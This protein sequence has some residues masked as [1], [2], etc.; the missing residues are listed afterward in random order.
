MQNKQTKIQ[1]YDITFLLWI[2]KSIKELYSYWKKS[3]ISGKLKSF[4]SKFELELSAIQR[5]NMEN[6]SNHKVKRKIRK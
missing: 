2:L 6:Y 3:Y 1:T 4:L 5:K